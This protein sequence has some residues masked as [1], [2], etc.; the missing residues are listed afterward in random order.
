MPQG[1]LV[2][3][4]GKRGRGAGAKLGR[5]EGPRWLI[6]ICLG[7]GVDPCLY[8]IGS[9]IRTTIDRQL[10]CAEE[11]DISSDRSRLRRMGSVPCVGPEKGR[12]RRA[13]RSSGDTRRG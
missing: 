11:I 6:L 2:G 9:A 1:W 5:S 4:G 3:Q 12:E 8:G 10:H 13:A 7:Y